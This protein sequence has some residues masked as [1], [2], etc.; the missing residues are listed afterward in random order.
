MPDPNWWTAAPG[1]L[2]NDPERQPREYEP[3]TRLPE[4][5]CS[6]CGILIERVSIAVAIDPYTVK[7]AC[8]ENCMHSLRAAGA[9]REIA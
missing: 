2:A 4:D 8:S 7:I 5:R 3:Q 1:E 9:D 6:V